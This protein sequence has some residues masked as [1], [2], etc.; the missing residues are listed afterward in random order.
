MLRGFLPYKV[1]VIVL[2]REALHL[3]MLAASVFLSI[4]WPIRGKDLR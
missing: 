1:N 4:L 2:C 3:L